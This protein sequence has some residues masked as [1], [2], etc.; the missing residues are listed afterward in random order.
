MET[1]QD[2]KLHSSTKV[3]LSHVIIP[4]ESNLEL[5]ADR[6]HPESPALLYIEKQLQ[7]FQAQLPVESDIEIV[8]GDPAEEI[9]RLANI[10]QADMIV[11]GCRGLTGLKRIVQGSVSSEVLEAANC[12]VLVVKPK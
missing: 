5:P 1:V 7:A 2:L 12:S 10:H 8:T 9:V 11:L 3:I 6:P 4:P